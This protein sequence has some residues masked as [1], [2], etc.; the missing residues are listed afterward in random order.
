M[1]RDMAIPGKRSVA[2]V[3]S[4]LQRR[5]RRPLGVPELRG[6]SVDGRYH[7]HVPHAVLSRS[8]SIHVPPRG[9][10]VPNGLV[11]KCS[12]VHASVESP[13]GLPLNMV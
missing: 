2:T 9:R 3:G 5:Q 11:R 1:T 8:S 13:W 7:R 12:V 4:V 6:Q 10:G